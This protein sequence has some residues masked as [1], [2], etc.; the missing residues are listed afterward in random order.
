HMVRAH[1]SF[2]MTIPAMICLIVSI[3]IMIREFT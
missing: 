2:L 3:M 1:Q